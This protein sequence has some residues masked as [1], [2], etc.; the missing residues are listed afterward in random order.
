MITIV[1]PTYNN[2]DY[3]KLCI[4][5]IKNN[6]SNKYKI[7]LHI[8][9]GTDGT[10]DYAND[11]NL[12]YTFSKKNLGLCTSLNNACKLVKTDYILY[13]HD[14]MYFCPGWDDA[15]IDEL[16]NQ[17]DIFFYL[18]GT[19]IEQCAG[20]IQYDCGNNLQNFDEKKLLN[21]YKN[22]PY[23]DHQGSHFAPHLIHKRIWDKIG[24]LSEEFNPGMCSDPD[25]N[26]K[27]WNEGVRIFKGINNFRV[28]HFGSLT[29]RKKKQ[30][31]QNKGHYTFLKKW[32][33][34]HKFFTK[35][36]LRSQQIFDG[37]LKEPK[38][39]FF[40]LVEL[41]ICKIKLLFLLFKNG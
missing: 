2:L 37:P 28:Y 18:S 3:L 19:M 14:D 24:G 22:L 26:M 6:S 35:Y 16:R 17:N 10:L 21:N 36:Y 23:Y 39:N 31:I 20:H 27:L 8:N 7:I 30:L 1:I 11:N 33:I 13:S 41:F 38:K 15:L 25:L 12:E 4:K 5:S 9:E 32:K 29:T 40:Y 34:T